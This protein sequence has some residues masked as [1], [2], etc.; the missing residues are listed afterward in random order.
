MKQNNKKPR[1]GRKKRER[2]KKVCA[3][4]GKL[5]VLVV[6]SSRLAWGRPVGNSYI[7]LGTNM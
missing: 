5:H 4:G 3:W 6:L 1:K 7:A 2:G